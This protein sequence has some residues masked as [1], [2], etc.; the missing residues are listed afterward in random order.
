ML[1]P[2]RLV[3]LGHSDRR[4]SRAEIFVTRLPFDC[5]NQLFEN[6]LEFILKKAHYMHRDV[7]IHLMPGAIPPDDDI[8]L[9]FELSDKRGNLVKVRHGGLRWGDNSLTVLH[10]NRFA[11]PGCCKS[12]HS[13]VGLFAFPPQ[14]VGRDQLFRPLERV[15][16]VPAGAANPPTDNPPIRILVGH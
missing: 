1:Y 4:L 10:N 12:S 16:L 7:C 13:Q 5:S 8:Q 15:P 2:S 3:H 9:A 11:P 6:R 14:L